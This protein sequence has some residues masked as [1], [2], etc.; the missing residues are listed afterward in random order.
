[1]RVR[2][3]ILCL[4]LWM[5]S[6]MAPTVYAAPR[7]QADDAEAVLDQVAAAQ[8]AAP[9]Y[10]DNF[11]QASDAWYTG[12]DEDAAYFFENGTYHIRVN[13]ESLLS[14]AMGD[15]TNLADFYLEVDAYYV[16]GPQN[17]ESGIVF[18]HLDDDNFYLFGV[19][20]DGLFSLRKKVDGEWTDLQEWTESDAIL[21]EESSVNAL[22]ILAQG[23]QIHLL[24]NGEVV[25]SVEDDE[26]SNGNL[27]LAV[28]TFDEGGVEIAFD[29]LRIWTSGEI[30]DAPDLTTP[31]STPEPDATPEPIDI[32]D[33]LAE[34]RDTDV[35]FSDEFRRDNGEW[36]TE[37]DEDITYEYAGR[38]L[39]IIVNSENRLGWTFNSTIEAL[40]PVDYLVEVDVE[41]VA[42][43]DD[44]E[45]GL[46][47]RFVDEE[48]FYFFA[49][50][51]LGTYSLWKLMDNEWEALINWTETTVL[52][53][54]AE[55]INRLSVL[56]EGSQFTL[57]VNDV[58]L[59]QVEDD[60]FA[61]GPVGLMVG[62]FDEVGVDVAF[63][64]L[65]LWVLATGED[66]IETPDETPTPQAAPIDVAERLAAIRAED[67]M[68]SDDF[69]RDNDAWDLEPTEDAT[70]FYRGRTFRIKVDAPE[71]IGWSTG[72]ITG[73]N[74]LLEV[75]TQYVAGPDDAEY[76][77]IFRQVDADNY[78]FFAISRSG[79]YG[80]WRLED[81]EWTTVIE[82]TMTDAIDVSEDALNRLGILAEGTQLTLL[83]NDVALAQVEDETF[84]SGKVAL[85]L[86]TFDEAG[87]EVAFDNLDIWAL[88]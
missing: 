66:A 5:T 6:G 34:I 19:G 8:A 1:M 60:T 44:A 46:I 33:R 10:S 49:V 9:A 84:A 3:V 13:A 35:T 26:F 47:F 86:G 73:T 15:I 63:D 85:A 68:T 72:E 14:W 7:H 53:T 30:S 17:N 28:S 75:D 56:T 50:S 88:E 67:P 74:F 59:A 25:A 78:Y 81:D 76:G 11:R 29:D 71:L 64:N 2:I 51:N 83:V 27:G 41:Q 61:T 23:E 4:V 37:S 32:S 58:A 22:G 40:A 48:N 80:L 82:W 12:E 57:L 65:D 54:D 70:F 45:L 31:E 16:A 36:F 77:V 55:A 43:P 38:T 20:N 79:S 24:I 21:V 62:T 42:G 52:Q 69:R 87:A 18:R 39:H